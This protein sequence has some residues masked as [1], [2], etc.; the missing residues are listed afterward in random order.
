V[1]VFVQNRARF[2][3]RIL[4]HVFDL[5]PQALHLIQM[6]LLVFHALMVTTQIETTCLR[7]SNAQTTLNQ[8]ALLPMV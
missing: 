6:E 3:Q 5:V 8:R 4:E 1:D 2:G 7:A